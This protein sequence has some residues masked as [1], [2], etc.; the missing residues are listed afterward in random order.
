VCVYDEFL[1]KII[2]IMYDYERNTPRKEKCTRVFF[3]NITVK[4]N[5]KKTVKVRLKKCA[6]F[7]CILTS[8]T[9]V[10]IEFVLRS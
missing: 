7:Y 1:G 5:F 2:I 4:K 8:D 3:K 10:A 9:C 6:C